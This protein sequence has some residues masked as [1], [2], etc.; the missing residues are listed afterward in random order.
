MNEIK[1]W[2][3]KNEDTSIEYRVDCSSR[4][5]VAN[6]DAD[7]SLPVEQIASSLAISPSSNGDAAEIKADKVDCLLAAS[8]GLITGALD[9]FW[10]G[11]FSIKDAQAWGREKTNDFVIAVARLRNYKGDSLQGAIKYL[12][13]QYVNPGD[14]VTADLGGSRQHHLR[15][16]SHHP[17][18]VGLIFSLLTQFSGKSYGTDTAG[19]FQSW[20]LP[21]SAPVGT[22]LEEKLELAVVQWAFHLVSDM[23]G[24]SQTP[25]G[26]TGIPGPFLSLLKEASALPLFQDATISYQDKEIAMS[27][28]LSKLFNGTAFPHSTY[29]DITRLDLRTETGLVKELSIEGLPVIANHCLVRAFHFL[30]RLFVSLRND[31]IRSF[32]DLG[33]LAVTASSLGNDRCLARMDT[34][35]CG[36]F[37]LVDGGEAVIRAGMHS[38]GDASAFFKELFLRINF[39]GIGCFVIAIKNDAGFI[40]SDIRNHYSANNTGQIASAAT[41]ISSSCVSLFLEMDDSS[42]YEF[43][44]NKLLQS[45]RSNKSSTDPLVK[46]AEKEK[47]PLF[48]LGDPNFNTNAYQIMVRQ[49]ENIAI[50]SVGELTWL[51]LVNNCIA[52]ELGA[53]E[54]V[55]LGAHQKQCSRERPVPFVMHDGDKRIGYVFSDGQLRDTQLKRFK[56]LNDLDGICV[57]ILA[58]PA[59]DS[60]FRDTI[61][62]LNRSSARK[63]LDYVRYDTLEYFYLRYLGAEKYEKLLKYIGAFN[64]RAR[65]IL[66]YNTIISPNE[67]T[68]GRFREA[69]SSSLVS[70]VETFSKILSEEGVYESQ[71]RLLNHNFIDRKLYL[72]MTGDS[73]FADSFVSSEW[74]YAIFEATRGLEQTGIVAGY[75]KSIE[76][77]LYAVACLSKGRGKTLRAKY[78]QE[79][80]EFNDENEASIDTSLASLNDLLMR[81][82]DL[83]S[84]NPF[85]KRYITHAIDNWRRSLRNG[86]FHK[87]NLHDV[88]R[89]KEIRDSARLLYFLIL[90]GCTIE[91]NDFA[92]L[93][94]VAHQTEGDGNL[95]E[96]ITYSRLSTWLDGL[97][98]DDPLFRFHLFSDGPNVV[99]SLDA[100]L[101]EITGDQFAKLFTSP[102]DRWVLRIQLTGTG[103]I[104]FPQCIEDIV[105]EGKKPF[106]WNFE[107]SWQDAFA[108]SSA[109]LRQYFGTSLSHE[110][111]TACSSIQLG[112]ADRE[113][114]SLI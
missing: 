69:C 9:I 27:Q 38:H 72:A 70:E 108:V 6:A 55:P 56:D 2:E 49:I 76:Q 77:L 20:T 97:F 3:G 73:L 4:Q 95:D 96:G 13:S 91:D 114:V 29:K 106:C 54:P 83:F 42:I 23:A 98:Y 81:N 44:F 28:M 71:L 85:V 89:V 111:L 67:E 5:N 25:G 46:K 90:G 22:T 68:I 39:L 112:S 36:V 87:D 99:L 78:S 45:A 104:T 32:R 57:L 17:T 65:A 79:R 86:Y 34:I 47:N 21:D 60:G 12:E 37:E 82:D 14:S 101:E 110:I 93:G 30:R 50:D 113:T 102:N 7:S 92:G 8:C 40:A 66:G 51:L 16:F 109:L 58:T 24:S 59:P 31:D 74:F 62:C 11:K 18:L 84:V 35:S 100:N 26:G 80:L 105:Y 43:E 53:Q 19:R 33:D 15:D 1:D 52:H 88:T 103:L 41:M 48:N 63:K 64:E 94:I 61:K 75:L 107:S 10:V